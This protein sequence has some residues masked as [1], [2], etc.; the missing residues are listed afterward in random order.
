MHR[1]IAVITIT[2]FKLIFFFFHKISKKYEKEGG[3]KFT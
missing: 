1:V 3:T 2:L